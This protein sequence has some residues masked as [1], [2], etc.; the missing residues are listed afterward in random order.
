MAD[1]IERMPNVLPP[2]TGP[3][4]RMPNVLPPTNW[5]PELQKINSNAV[6][7]YQPNEIAISRTEA[8][9]LAQDVV[10]IPTAGNAICQYLVIRDFGVNWRHIKSTTRTHPLLV[11]QLFRFETDKSLQFQIVG[12][13]D[14]AGN[15]RNNSFLRTGRARN[16]FRLLGHDARSRV[17]AVKAAP[18]HTYLTD[19]STVPARAENRSVVIEIFVNA[20]GSGTL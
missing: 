20:S 6:F 17:F 19:N 14:C 2:N 13:S 3:T 11:M 15:E 5:C 9:H 16:V 8:G 7:P 10:I 18:P 1:P 4:E 12:Y